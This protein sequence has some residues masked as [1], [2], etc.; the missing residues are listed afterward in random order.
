VTEKE[1]GKIINFA[2]GIL[3]IDE[4]IGLTQYLASVVKE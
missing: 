1:A 3:N 4:L 2:T